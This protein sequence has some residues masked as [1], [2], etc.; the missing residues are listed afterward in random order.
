MKR[1]V[2]L[3]LL[4]CSKEPAPAPPYVETREPCADRNPLRNVYFG[5]LHV[6]TTLS[7]DAHIYEVKTTPAQ[8]YRFAQGD[9]LELP[10]PRTARLERPLDFAAVTDHSEYLGEVELCTTP[11]TAAFDSKTCQAYRG[12]DKNDAVTAFGLKFALPAPSRF[13]DTCGDDGSAC[14]SRAAEV[15]SRVQTAA[16]DAYDRS[17]R[18]SFTTFVAYEY[19]GS[20]GASNLHRNVIFRTDRVPQPIS[21]FEQPTPAGLWRELDSA[22][23]Q[24]ID[25]CDVLAI[26]HNSNESNG[27]MFFVEQG[28]EEN[29]ALRAAMEPLMEVYQHKGDSE[30]RNGLSGILGAADEQCAFEKIPRENETDCGDGTGVQ[31]VANRGCFSRLDFA[32][33]AL[34]QGLEEKARTGT[35]PYRLGLVGSTDTHNGTPGNVDEKSFRGH[36]GVDDN[37]PPALF[38]ALRRREV[39]AT[40]GPRIAVRL[41][42]GNVDR[43]A[44]GQ[45]DLVAKAYASA[46]PMG[47]TLPR[48]GA[49]PS[50]VVAALR[51]PNGGLLQRVQIIKGWLDAAG[52]HIQ[53]HDVAGD[54]NNGARVDTDTCV[55]SGPGASDLCA[56]WTDAAFDPAQHAFYYARVLENPSCRWNAYLCNSLPEAERPARCKD[57]PRTIQ[58]RAWTSPIWYEP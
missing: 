15:W 26:P 57:A 18:C 45:A 1:L 19:S 28:A 46:V 36:V 30:C 23:K 4:G 16:R 5:D 56:V 40:S 22:C 35:N 58:E 14:V 24:K 49:A 7:F 50:F 3:L 8:A 37:T 11:G 27:K 41:F 38:D 54:A 51:D 25:G 34:L 43:G 6:H 12:A 33:G 21:Y 10:G 47:G 44:C 9:P 48:G 29:H 55:P 53:V 17:A 2:L 32:R 31:G 13:V 52:S 20:T 39:F 42:G